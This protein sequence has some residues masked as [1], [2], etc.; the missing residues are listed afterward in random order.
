MFNPHHRKNLRRLVR[1]LEKAYPDRVKKITYSLQSELNDAI[2]AMSKISSKTYQRALGCGFFDDDIT[3]N[4]LKV[5]AK[6]GKLRADVLFIDEEPAAFDLKIIYGRTL[7]GETKGYDPKWAKYCV[8]TVLFLK[9]IEETCQN[10]AVD[11][12]DFGFGYAEY[13]QHFANQKWDE[14]SLEI[15]APRVFLIVINI[16]QSSARGL[17][18]AIKHVLNKTALTGWIKR[19]WRNFLQANNSCEKKDT[20]LNTQ[21]L[22]NN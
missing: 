17:S 11:S 8:G 7:F 22:K 10:P 16:L 5:E 3:K 14:A 6:R 13:K 19:K 12:L 9:F 15:F 21:S 1:R 4:L 20:E 2:N 18:L